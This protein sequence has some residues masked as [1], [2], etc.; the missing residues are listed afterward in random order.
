MSEA[1]LV[2]FL[3]GWE[4][5]RNCKL[6]YLAAK[7]FDIEVELEETVIERIKNLQV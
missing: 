1:S 2:Y 5:D 3:S 6:E 4:N 7:E